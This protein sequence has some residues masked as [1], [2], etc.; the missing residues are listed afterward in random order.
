MPNTW[1]TFVKCGSTQNYTITTT[2][3]FQVR[4]NGFVPNSPILLENTHKIV[5]NPHDTT[6]ANLYF[7]NFSLAILSLTLVFSSLHLATFS[8]SIAA[9]SLS[10]ASF[11]FSCANL[12]WF[13]YILNLARTM[14]ATSD[15]CIHVLP[16]NH[17]NY[18]QVGSSSYKQNQIRVIHKAN[19]TRKLKKKKIWKPTVTH[20][21]L[22]AAPIKLSPKIVQGQSNP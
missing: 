22:V 4:H 16:S 13:L 11:S 10:L 3:C 9:F 21:I 8:L 12:A 19:K 15:P 20:H 18:L 14:G 6:S 5:K 1:N 2:T 17:L 7:C